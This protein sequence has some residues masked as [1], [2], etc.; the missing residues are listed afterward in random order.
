MLA[1]KMSSRV[2]K[3]CRKVE[4]RRKERGG[5]IGLMLQKKEMALRGL[6]LTVEKNFPE[7][8]ILG[9]AGKQEN[10]QGFQALYDSFHTTFLNIIKE[11]YCSLIFSTFCS[12]L[13][14]SIEKERCSY[15]GRRREFSL[16][17]QGGKYNVSTLPDGR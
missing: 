7:C 17:Q 12:C 3:C 1:V 4:E 5:K 6:A 10:Q 8:I 2:S 16:Q 14:R 13:R 11:I 9:L 15:F